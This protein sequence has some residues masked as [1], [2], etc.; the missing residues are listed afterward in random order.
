MVIG[1]QETEE[2]V[3]NCILN[4]NMTFEISILNS[5]NNLISSQKYF[6]NDAGKIMKRF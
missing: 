3:I 5:S 2:K 4:Q 6:I 1:G